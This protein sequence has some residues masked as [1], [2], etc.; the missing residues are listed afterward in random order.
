MNKTA[1]SFHLQFYISCVILPSRTIGSLFYAA[2]K[3]ETS[4]ILLDSVQGGSL[5]ISV[6]LNQNPNFMLTTKSTAS[7]LMFQENES[8]FL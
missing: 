5:T 2:N 1:A 6:G 7:V 4:N 8:E 3:N